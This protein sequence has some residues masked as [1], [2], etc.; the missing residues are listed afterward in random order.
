MFSPTAV[1]SQSVSVLPDTLWVSNA[2]IHKVVEGHVIQVHCIATGFTAPTAITWTKDGTDVSHDPPHIFIRTPVDG[3]TSV[4]TIDQFDASD[5]GLYLCSITGVSGFATSGPLNLT[6]KSVQF[7]LWFVLELKSTVRYVHLWCSYAK[8]V[9]YVA[10]IV[11]LC[12]RLLR[13]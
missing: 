7:V 8:V 6:S 4:L 10:A 11:M 5:D 13:V 12:I 2:G 1:D 9:Y 3:L